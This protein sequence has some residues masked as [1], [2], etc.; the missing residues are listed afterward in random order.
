MNQSFLCSLNLSFLFAT[1]LP[2][3]SGTTK[4]LLLNNTAITTVNLFAKHFLVV[5]VLTVLK[6]AF[7]GKKR[8]YSKNKVLLNEFANF[9]HPFKLIKLLSRQL[10]RISRQQ[11]K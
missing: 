6:S 9:A 8:A 2:G 11:I 7:K 4:T 1:R 10:Y 3:D 5:I